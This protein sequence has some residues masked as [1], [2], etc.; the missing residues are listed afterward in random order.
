MELHSDSIPEPLIKFFNCNC[1]TKGRYK[2]PHNSAFSKLYRTTLGTNPTKRFSEAHKIFKNF[3]GYWFIAKY[4]RAQ[5]KKGQLYLKVVH[6]EPENP[7]R[8]DAWTLDGTLKKTA[9]KATFTPTESEDNQGIIRGQSGDNQG[10]IRGQSGDRETLK[11]SNSLG[12]EAVFHPTKKHHNQGKTTNTKDLTC[13][14]Q[15]FINLT[16]TAK[17]F[18]ND[19]LDV[20]LKSFG[21]KNPEAETLAMQAVL[22]KYGQ[23]A[24]LPKP[25]SEQTNDEWLSEFNRLD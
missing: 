10:I 18:Y 19:R 23:D 11:A 13:D 16:D 3:R 4:E 5:L 24:Y 9:K 8:N 17:G 25:V 14:A 20:L 6:I 1:T 2:V 7:A 21:F 15:L 22:K 12:L